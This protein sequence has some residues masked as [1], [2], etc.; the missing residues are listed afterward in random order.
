MIERLN[1]P[2]PW[3]E[4]TDPVER[5]A[6]ARSLAVVAD[7][8]RVLHGQKFEVVAANDDDALL[9]CLENGWLA[10]ADHSDSAGWRVRA[11]YDDLDIWRAAWIER[12]RFVAQGD[13]WRT[14]TPEVRAEMRRRLVAL[15]A[16]H[17]G[18]RPNR[19]EDQTRLWHDLHIHG[20]DV[21]ELFAAIEREFAIV[22]EAHDGVRYF[23]G[24]GQRFDAL[25]CRLLGRK[26]PDYRPITV[27]HL[28]AV[29]ERGQWFMPEAP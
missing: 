16:A 22:I 6:C 8:R 4:Q 13:H 23:P 15:I 29:V 27:D 9:L 12:Q 5:A 25:F 7:P 26:P 24:E 1:L 28:M 11:L 17:S 19:I 21:D 3:R 18:A 14:G 20:D 10:Q 2:A